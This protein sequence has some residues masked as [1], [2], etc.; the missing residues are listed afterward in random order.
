MIAGWMWGLWGTPLPIRQKCKAIDDRPINTPT[1]PANN[2][3]YAA[4]RISDAMNL[5]SS[6]RFI[7]LLE[8]RSVPV[9]APPPAS[10]PA[11]L[12]EEEGGAAGI[13]GIAGERWW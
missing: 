3:A 12:E 2:A 4:D 8:V 10:P 13:A 1:T 6:N 7:T 5:M 11:E 9:P